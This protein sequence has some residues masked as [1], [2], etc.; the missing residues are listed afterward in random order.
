MTYFIHISLGGPFYK[1]TAG[2]KEYNFELPSYCGLVPINK[3]LSER[4]SPMPRAFWNAV[5]K[6]QEQGE[7]M[8]DGE[9]IWEFGPSLPRERKAEGWCDG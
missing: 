8:K 6:W 2:G 9:C 5:N 7:R 1:I 4:T 3:D